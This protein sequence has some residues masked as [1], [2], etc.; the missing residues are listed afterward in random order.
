MRFL[1]PSAFAVLAL[2]PL[3]VL[4]L[5]W[6]QR[7]RRRF[8]VRY[9]SLSLVRAALPAQSKL[10]RYLPLAL[11]FLALGS[12]VVALARPVTVTRVPAGRATVMLVLDVSGSMRQTDIRPSRLG[13]AKQAAME[14][15]DSQNDVNQI[16]VVAFARI[17]QLVQPP[18]TDADELKQAIR[19]LT[20]G[21][22]TAIGEG[23]L[24]GLQT[25]TDFKQGSAA[26]PTPA[27]T[28]AP[29]G[30][31]DYLPDIIV[32]LTDGVT[33]GG[34]D[35]IEAAG[36]A[37]DSRVRIYTIGFG[38]T[39]GSLGEFGGGGG[40][41][42]RRGWGID[43]ASLK[44]IAAMTGGEYYTAGSANELKK[45]FDSL[46]RV[47]VS[48]EETLEVSVAFAALAAALVAGAV[49]LAQLWH[50]LP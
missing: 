14:F 31:G 47:L 25:I 29:F 5:A 10:R 43:E 15:I 34:T 17:A 12:L 41:Y 18:S 4:L 50:P 13:A 40:D 24:T 23:I 30:E 32:L 8:A 19:G 21:R 2:I 35:P 7:R 22:G 45:V 48:R 1:W 44:E 36:L 38:T 42:R 33:T 11:F 37:R 27:P 39:N 28:R 6:R 20:T 3:L 49:L 16:G 9:S 46:P 26:A